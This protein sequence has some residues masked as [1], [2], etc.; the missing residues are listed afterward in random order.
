MSSSAESASEKPQR[1]TI[2]PRPAFVLDNLDIK[3]GIELAVKQTTNQDLPSG[4][5]CGDA[6]A[7]ARRLKTLAADGTP[8][9][10]IVIAT[11][12]F[13][14]KFMKSLQGKGISVVVIGKDSQNPTKEAVDAIQRLIQ[15]GA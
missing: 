4:F 5:V 11:Q 3:N 15:P 7:L 1:Q 6:A 8:F 9:P 10:N 14:P 12:R 13:T 2:L